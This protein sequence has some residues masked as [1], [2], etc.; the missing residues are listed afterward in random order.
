MMKAIWILE[1]AKLE[2]QKVALEKNK[3]EF[4]V[5]AQSNG[6][7]HLNSPLTSGM[8]VQGGS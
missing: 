5:L 7:V 3:E 4:K 2:A 6:I 8:V 1:V